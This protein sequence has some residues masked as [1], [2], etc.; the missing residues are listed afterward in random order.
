MNL[1]ESILFVSNPN[2]GLKQVLAELKPDKVAYLVDENTRAHCLPLFD[3]PADANIIEIKSGEINK[4]LNTCAEIWT[5]LTN[6]GFSRKSLLVNIGGGVIG[7]MGGFCASTYKRGIRFVNFPTTLL[8]MVD[9]NIGGKLGI[10][11]MG[12]KN[13]LGVFQ[14]PAKVLINVEF[15][16][17]LSPRELRSG[18]AEVIKHGLIHDKPY[19][20]TIENGKFPEFDWKSIVATSVEIKHQVVTEDPKES[21]LRKILNFGHTLGHAIETWH[22]NHNISLLHGEAIAVGMILE[23][24]LAMQQNTLTADE[25]ESLTAY[26]DTTYD[27]IALPELDVLFP[28]MLQDKKNIGNELSFSLL[29]GIGKCLFDQRVTEPMIIAAMNYYSNLK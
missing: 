6:W 27:R 16:K 9:A 26:I 7:D 3:L 25:L 20:E 15:L 22:L 2:E 10:D 24:H 12:F 19:W 4:N 17:T 5:A 28:L 14:D 13:H 18:F 23:G 8:A 21:G 1:P 29:D 11:F